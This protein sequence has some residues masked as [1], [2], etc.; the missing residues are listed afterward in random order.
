ML[1]AEQ[2]DRFS[3]PISAL[4]VQ[5][6]RLWAVLVSTPVFVGSGFVAKYPQGGGNFWVPLQYFLGL[7]Q[8]AIDAFWL[9][10]LSATGN[11]SED[12]NRISI[13]FARAER[14]GLEGRALVLYLPEGPDSDRQE[15]I[16]PTIPAA[17]IAARM[18]QGLL[19][20][21]ANSIPKRHRAGFAR[22]IL[23]DIDPGM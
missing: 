20:N 21:F 17:E 19:L 1:S 14:L 15:L 3:E 10:L 2:I 11:E 4:S 12:R 13:F 9:E 18:R 6:R 23:Y 5:R 22:A 7:R 8:H 16:S